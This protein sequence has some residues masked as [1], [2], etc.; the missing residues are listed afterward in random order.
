MF[1]RIEKYKLQKPGSNSTNIIK[2]SGL[3]FSHLGINTC[4][5][6]QKSEEIQILV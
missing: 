2:V 6:F 1:I 4:I 5:P 3:I